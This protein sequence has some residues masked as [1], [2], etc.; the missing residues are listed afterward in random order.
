VFELEDFGDAVTPEIA[1]REE[2]LRAEV[3]DRA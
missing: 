3:A 1:E 2:R